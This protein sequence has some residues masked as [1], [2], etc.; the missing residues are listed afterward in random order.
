[1]QEGLVYKEIHLYYLVVRIAQYIFNTQN[2]YV[3][4]GYQ[5]TRVYN[6]TFINSL[7]NKNIYFS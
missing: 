2:D 7:N 5:R 4:H 1:M 3:L 6:I